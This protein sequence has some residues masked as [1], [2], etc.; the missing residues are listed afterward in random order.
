MHLKPV[1]AAA[2]AAAVGGVLVLGL[3]AAQ[4]AK[5]TPDYDHVPCGTGA[6][7]YAMTHLG[8]DETVYLA[9]GCT[10]YLDDE[11][12]VDKN[13]VTLVGYDT[14]LQGPGQGKNFTILYVDC[15]KHLTIDD[16]NFTRADGD[17]SDGGAIDSDGGH[18]TINGG[19]F[20][21]NDDY[22]SSVYS[23]N[24][25]SL[26]I[27]GAIF[28]GNEGV[29]AGAVAIYGG[30]LNVSGSTFDQNNANGYDGGAIY[31]GAKTGT[32]STSE[33]LGNTAYKGGAIYLDDENSLTLTGGD[34]FTGNRAWEGGAIYNDGTL[35]ANLDD[36]GRY[37]WIFFNAATHEGGGIYNDDDCTQGDAEVD[38]NVVN[39]IYPYGSC[40]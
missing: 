7:N 9:A 20:S 17:S 15:T 34:M 1:T 23:E 14:T 36:S 33:F 18:V 24:G 40:S 6:L 8:N 31:T 35:T 27:N 4:A 25:G 19:T 22:Y 39:N 26:D 5:A 13:H 37:S 28:T 11:F 29:Y 38:G 32:I 3:G 16:V 21:D 30:T 12:T 10:Y 2:R